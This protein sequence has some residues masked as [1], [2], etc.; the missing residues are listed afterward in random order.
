MHAR[1][2]NGLVVEYP[3]INLYQRLPE[4]SLPAD[5]TNDAALPEGFVYVHASLAPA[6]NTITHRV[7]GRPP[8]LIGDIWVEQWAVVA[9]DSSEAEDNRI[10]AAAARWQEIKGI[11]DRKTQ[12]GGY[13]VGTD[14]FHSD[15]FSRTQ[16]I[17]LTM[18]GASMPANLTWKTMAG[19]FVPMTPTLAQQIFVS[20]GQQDAALFAYAESLRAQVE[21]AQNPATVDIEAGWPETFNGI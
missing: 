6:V 7:E 17:G 19:T 12:N 1:I 3:I 16:Q 11:R 2:E 5:I 18:Y 4:V 13:K 10:A 9:V 20:A 14:W 8:A 21:A 15:T